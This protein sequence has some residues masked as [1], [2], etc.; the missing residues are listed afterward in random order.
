M[1][2]VGS[3]VTGSSSSLMVP[4][5]VPVAMVAPVGLPRVTVKVSSGSSS[6]SS[7]VWTEMVL[8]SSSAAKVS[9]P[10]APV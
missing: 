10:D 4:V 6:V 1:L 5:A 9:V 7:V 8:E 3:G 2:R